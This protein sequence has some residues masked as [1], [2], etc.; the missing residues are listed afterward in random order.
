[1]PDQKPDER[2]MPA[3]ASELAPPRLTLRHEAKESSGVT[4]AMVLAYVESEGGREAVRKVLARCGLQLCEAELRDENTWFSWETKI[5]LFT[6]AGEVLQCPDFLERMG[7]FVL[8][9]NVAGGLKVA[10]RT[11]GSPQFVLRNIV[12]ANAR[13]VRSHVL[14]LLALE[15]G[16]ARLRFTSLGDPPRYHRLDCDYT[17]ALLA[18]IPGLFGLPPASVSHHQCAARGAVACIFDLRWQERPAIGRRLA[19]SGVGLAAAGTAGALLAPVTLPLVGAGAVVAGSLAVRERVCWRREQWRHL[20]RQVDQSEEV[21][22]RLFA[23]LQDLVSDLRLEEVVAKV[24]RN[25]RAAVGGQE[26]LLL[27]REGDRVICQTASELP[28]PAVAAVEEWANQ[29]P[30]AL[31]VSA[32]LDDVALVPALAPL[33]HLPDP[34]CTLACAPLTAGTN[35]LG[36]LVSLGGQ[37]GTFLPRDMSVLESYAAQVALALGN[38]RRYQDQRSLAARDPLT[39]LLN[40]RRFHEAVAD[41]FERCARERFFSSLVLID[42]DHFK[43]VNDEDGHG[44]GDRVLRAAARALADVCRRDDLAFRIGGDEFALLLPK[45]TEPGAAAVAGR[46][47]AAIELIDPRV[48]ASAGVAVI[49]PGETDKDTVIAHADRRLYDAKRRG[50]R[51]RRPGDGATMAAAV[52]LLS[53]AL[54]L[55]HGDTEAHSRTVGELAVAVAA[56]LRLSPTEQEFV[57]HVAQLHDLGKLGLP[58]GLLDKPA[59]LTGAEWTLVRRHPADGAELLRRV[60]G[61]EPLAAAVQASHERW[62]GQ[63]YPQQL[64]G[65]AIPLAARIVAACDA[66][67]AMTAGRPYRRSFTLSEAIGELRACSGSQFDPGVV[68]ALVAELS[69]AAR[70]A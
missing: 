18:V 47:C 57:H 67:E 44:A 3:A 7:S 51:A 46:V 37:P 14:E 53:G 2:F 24:T 16:Y 65:E 61:L 23:S 5:A 12:R 39:G 22:Q 13:F 52:R 40:H 63:G 62:D 28:R 20:R 55:H 70:A 30:E 31:E 58:P 32:L 27:V 45:L 21:A 56:R 15:E 59:Q 6:A 8:D 41:E 33:A 4:S 38:A 17:S 43:R 35:S 50:P 26:F 34:L 69:P 1:M 29:T 48:G 11:L 60:E 10:L 36:L 66:L 9:A 68:E 19:L 42:L 64:R 49:S 25:A 54:A